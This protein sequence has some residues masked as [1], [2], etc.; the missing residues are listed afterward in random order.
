M[1][2]K[3][4]KIKYFLWFIINNN[5]IIYHHHGNEFLKNAPFPAAG[6]RGADTLKFWFATTRGRSEPSVL[7][8]KHQRADARARR[9]TRLKQTLKTGNLRKTVTKSK[10]IKKLLLLLIIIIIN[11]II[12]ES[13]LTNRQHAR[14]LLRSFSDLTFLLSVSCRSCESCAALRRA[15]S[16]RSTSVPEELATQP[17]VKSAVPAGECADAA[18]VRPGESGTRVES[19]RTAAGASL[20]PDEAVRSSAGTPL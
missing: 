4:K 12:I 19:P 2:I 9:P 3:C 20:Q 13:V 18:A 11:I 6:Q 14:D 8:K 15:S 1:R 17:I 5:D 16:C 10:S 7:A